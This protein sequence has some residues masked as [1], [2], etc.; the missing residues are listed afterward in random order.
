MKNQTFAFLLFLIIGNQVFAQ[1][2]GDTIV[3]NTFNY[4]MTYGSGIRDTVIAFPNIPGVSYEKILMQYNMRCK[5]GAVSTGSNTNL[6]CG[7]WDYSCNTYLHD[8]T[9]VDSLASQTNSH[10]IPTFSGTTF[11]YTNSP[12]YSTYPYTQQNVVLN[13]I[14][15]EVQST[16]GSGNLPNL[17]AINTQEFGGKS[18]Y[19]FTA[20]ELS[21]AGVVA[22]NLD[23][24]I[25][26]ILSGTV[27]SDFLRV[28]I[29]HTTNS[30]LSGSS[31]ELSGW[32][33]VYFQNTSFVVGLNRLQFYQ[34]FNWD[35]ISNV[36]VEISFNNGALGSA[37]SVK[38]HDALS[39]KGLTSSGDHF[40]LFNGVNYFEADNYTGVS[41]TTSRTIEA[42]IKTTV[43]D[44]E[45]VSWGSDISGQKWV[46]RLNNVGQLR[47]EVNGGFNV[48]TSDLRD[49][50]WH[51][52][53]MR[54]QGNN[55]NTIQFFVD[56]VQET[57][58]STG[59]LAINTG[60][61]YKVRISRGVNN[62]YWDGEIDEVRIWDTY[63]TPTTMT[64][65]NRRKLD[66]THPNYANLQAYYNM[67]QNSGNTLSDAS[68]NGNDMTGVNGFQWDYIRGDKLFKDFEET[69]I[70][71]NITFAQ[72]T[73][74]QTVT[75][76]I[77]NDTI[78][79]FPY[80]VTPYTINS[81][82]GTVFSDQIVAGTSQNL[83][84]A[85][86]NYEYDL[87]GILVDSTPVTAQGTINITP[88]DYYQRWP[89]KFEIMSFVTPYG[90]NL[91]MGPNGKTWTFDMTDYSP[92]LKGNKRITM[93]R[94]GQWQEDMDIKFLFIVGT[95]YRDVLDIREVW[96]T[97]SRGYTS[98]MN[99]QYFEPIDV[100][101]LPNGEA[102]KV[103]TS[104]SG[105]GQEGEF[106]PRQ[107]FLN[108]NGGASEFTW[109]VWKECAE[110]PVYPQGGTWIY[111]RAGWC[112]GMATDV[113]HNDITSMVTAGSPVNLDYGVSTASGTSNYI[114]SNQ[115]VTYG[116]INKTLDAAIVQI[117]QP[118]DAVEFE[119][120]NSICHTPKATLK[121]TGSTTL[122]SATINYW[123][124]NAATPR[125]YNWTGSLASGD[126][127][128][129]DLPSSYELW[130]SLSQTTNVFHVEV[131]NPNG[132]TD[133]YSFNNHFR[134]N[135]SIPD[136]MPSDI[137]I[138]FKTNAFPGE[139]SYQILDEQNNVVLSRSG[140]AA[141]TTYK[142]TVSLPMGCYKYQVLDTDDDGISFW[143]NNDGSGYT[144]IKE[145]GGIYLKLFNGDFG[146]N[147]NYNFTVNFPLSYEELNEVE[148]LKIYPNPAQNE[149][150]FTLRNYESEVTIKIIDNLGKEIQSQRFT[151][152]SNVLNGKMDISDLPSGLYVVSVSDGNRTSHVKVIKN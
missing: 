9:R 127:T 29:K 8:S 101:T 30:L 100:P 23:G 31:P 68:G 128:E 133:E 98:I 149:L 39:I 86:Y 41:G 107:H 70:R 53:A 79:N 97:E 105:H 12:T 42:W 59:A 136:V 85:T 84:E 147:I 50:N 65:W 58:S 129:V 25:L 80:V 95:P 109:D 62:R 151:N 48:G 56:G 106:I 51:H 137:I 135:F 130:N 113:K 60:S 22:G 139:N 152:T 90:I 115:L 19:L 99:N 89:M 43:G 94:G 11:N 150:N 32:T 142:D 10:L 124:N 37:L 71:P 14:T 91:N 55:T 7:E 27:T 72:G 34:A 38:S 28:N 33:N 73:Y 125:V 104:V 44:K 67:N 108:V 117:S 61:A 26:D 52:V 131:T 21:S 114:V 102:F 15:S 66:A 74:S 45:I 132:G 111:D 6:G 126:E 77:V 138:E 46:F 143:A 82:A 75:P 145:V 118:T 5:N 121:N 24:I 18:Q 1:N 54:F 120:F 57:I 93:E 20:T 119:R 134:T 112:P 16:V 36:I 13:S 40:P 110:N 47:L 122:T 87:A 2:P 148:D 64:D 49:G 144:R 4:G 103:R 116:A 3:V 35:G 92:V 96:R 141:N 83:W 81:Q 123:V 88:L 63:I 146:D 69:S 140:M 78:F 76:T 17:K